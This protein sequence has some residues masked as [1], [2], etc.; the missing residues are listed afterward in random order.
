MTRTKMPGLRLGAQVA[1]VLCTLTTI[2]ACNSGGRQPASA[3]TRSDSGNTTMA[4]GSE[5]AH[6]AVVTNAQGEVV[7]AQ[8]LDVKFR[9]SDV[10]EAG[11]EPSIGVTSS[12]CMFF[13]ALEKVMRSCDQGQSW[14]SVEDVFSQPTTSDPYLWVDPI[15]D[16]I[17]NV[18]MVSL[19]TTWIAWSDDDGETWLGNPFDNG[20]I[21]VNDHIKL[22]T[23][24]WTQ[25]GYGQL[26]NMAPIHDTATYFCFN[27]LVGVFC[28]TSL[29]GGASF[30]LGAEVT[31]VAASG[32]L[33]GAIT[34]APDGTVYVP[35]RTLI[36]TVAY[37]KDNG[38]TWVETQMGEDTLT[39]SPRKN[40]EVGTDSASNAYHVWIGED[41][42]VYM[43][44]S[45]DSGVSWDQDSIRVSP[46]TVVSSTFPHIDAGDPGRI[47]VAY[48]GS[49]DAQFLRGPD[50][51]N[52][53]WRGNPHTA[54]NDA[55][56]HL[57]VTFSLNALDDEPVFYTYKITD[58]PVQR[59]SICISSG[60][61]RQ[62]GGSNRN[63]LDFNDLHIDAEG[64]VYIAYAD[65]CIGPCAE[66]GDAL[67][68]RDA[69][70]FAAILERGPSLLAQQQPFVSLAP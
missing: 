11:P 20:P 34:T 19:V 40:S 31:G 42:G 65:G 50:I 55:E 58:D 32:G 21:P 56:Y 14:E 61:C 51:D 41:M 48:L 30:P 3:D 69:R 33:H 29:D 1:V 47:A 53:P 60:D 49:E 12:G 10:G 66:V 23:G 46:K 68:S 67:S 4:P 45:T 52:V 27:K 9:L 44:R 15:T 35:P 2:S 38:L 25:S 26:G 37:S 28:Y 64:R 59:G 70:G 57:Y 7:A 62:I 18:Q 43:S 22:A 8:P 5:A 24:P 36:P 6:P 13:T 39:P 17:Y 16:R 54:P 63:L